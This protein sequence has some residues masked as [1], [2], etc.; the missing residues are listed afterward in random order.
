M[1]IV[2]ASHRDL[3]DMVR[4]GEFRGDLYHRLSVFKLALPPLRE[5]KEDL[6]DLVGLFVAEFNAKAGK[7]VKVVP[8][9]AWAELRAH[10]WPGNVRELRNVI[11]RCVLFAEG[12]QLPA[13]WLQLRRNDARGMPA[14]DTATADGVFIPLDGSMALDDMDCYIIRTTLERHDGNVTAAARALG[15][16]RET[17]RYRIRKYGLKESS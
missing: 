10:D 11:E 14:D 17:L 2:A 15:A 5:V 9:A 7:H 4:R 12:P 13:E 3:E 6:M 1:Q 16:T 8:E